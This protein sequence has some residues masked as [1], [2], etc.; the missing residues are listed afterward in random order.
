MVVVVVALFKK[1][2]GDYYGKNETEENK[3]DPWNFGIRIGKGDKRERRKKKL[4]RRSR[5]KGRRVKDP[6]YDFVLII[7][8]FFWSNAKNNTFW[9]INFSGSAASIILTRI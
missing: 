6:L 1:G 3:L 4:G 7:T 2:K 5:R 9:N 8:F